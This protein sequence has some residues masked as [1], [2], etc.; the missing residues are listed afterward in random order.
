MAA[1]IPDCPTCTELDSPCVHR[2][3]YEEA[4]KHILVAYR[5]VSIT[6]KS[7]DCPESYWIAG[8]TRD[9]KTIWMWRSACRVY[10]WAMLLSVLVHEYGHNLWFDVC[11]KQPDCLD[12]E[13]KANEYGFNAMPKDLVP[14]LYQPYREF[15]LSSYRDKLVGTIWDEEIC[16]CKYQDWLKSL[17]VGGVR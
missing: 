5:P 13:V 8:K 12:D 9:Y 6:D 15:F 16:L 1:T 3:Q 7:E 14:V 4:E 17:S 11:L 10:G 2:Q